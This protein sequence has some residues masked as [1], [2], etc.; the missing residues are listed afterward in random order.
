VTTYQIDGLGQTSLGGDLN[1]TV[2]ATTLIVQAESG[3]VLIP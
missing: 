3:Y 1:V 2:G